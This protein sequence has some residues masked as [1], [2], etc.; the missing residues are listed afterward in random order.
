MSGPCDDE[1]YKTNDS[2][3]F[4]H[5][6]INVCVGESVINYRIVFYCWMDQNLFIGVPVGVSSY[7]CIS[8]RSSCWPSISS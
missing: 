2:C 4:I 3:K 5:D 8:H 6:N 1:L 7:C